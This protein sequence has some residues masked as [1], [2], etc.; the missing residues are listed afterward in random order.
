MAGK[1]KDP[2]WLRQLRALDKAAQISF[3]VKI[4][5]IGSFVLGKAAVA[6]GLLRYGP[7]ET[8]VDP[9][10]PYSVLDI[11]SNSPDWLIP[12]AYRA[13]AKKAHPDAG[14][15]NEE[16]KRVNAAFDKIKAE[17]SMS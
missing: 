15:S 9:N 5:D 17:R 2:E 8:T 13:R 6:L 1:E 10:D 4:S 11:P 14:G 12:L 3:N 7:A 16:M